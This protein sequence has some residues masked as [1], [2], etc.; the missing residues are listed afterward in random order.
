MYIILY[1]VIQNNLIT[2]TIMFTKINKIG[3]QS[4]CNNKWTKFIMPCV[5]LIL[6]AGSNSEL[7]IRHHLLK[8][9]Q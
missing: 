9:V 2:H 5:N 3:L 1:N 6:L 8:I 7:L 4:V